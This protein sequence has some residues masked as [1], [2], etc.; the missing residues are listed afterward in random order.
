M[1]P[2][3]MTFIGKNI[4]LQ[5]RHKMLP[6]A[7]GFKENKNIVG[8]R[9][10]PR[11]KHLVLISQ[12]FQKLFILALLTYRIFEKEFYPFPNKP[13]F[14]RVCNTSLLKT[15]REKEIL[16]VTSNF[17]FFHCVFYPFGELTAIS[18]KFEIV[19]RQ[20]SEFE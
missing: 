8:K 14:L 20:L 1:N 19:V 11:Y 12:C 6:D 17:S 9:E 3:A 4:G 16:L 18:M 10:N 2:V 7:F 5:T 13:W 15:M